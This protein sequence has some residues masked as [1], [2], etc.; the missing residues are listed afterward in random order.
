MGRLV[1]L[2]WSL[3]APSMTP[4]SVSLCFALLLM[5]TL[6]FGEPIYALQKSGSKENTKLVL[7]VDYLYA[8]SEADKISGATYS[9]KFSN[10]VLAGI[11]LGRIIFSSIYLGGRYDYWY[12]QRQI[13]LSGVSQSDDLKLQTISLEVGYISDNPRIF[14]LIAGGVCYP[15]NSAVESKT[16]GDHLYESSK[17]ELMYSV[18]VQFGVRFTSWYAFAIEGG[19]RYANMGKLQEG[20]VDYLPGGKELNLSSPFL[21][22]GL[23]FEF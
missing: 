19:Y 9:R 10:P 18:R 8:N 6:I 22:L 3:V 2:Y 11:N 15:F 16:T 23:M 13:H 12:G 21:G 4:R 17:K 14:M 7:I 1:L 5:S 20:G